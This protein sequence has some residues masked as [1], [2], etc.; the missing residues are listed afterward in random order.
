MMASKVRKRHVSGIGW[1][2]E[3]PGGRPVAIQADDGSLARVVSGVVGTKEAAAILGVLPPNFVRDWS[4]RPDFPRPIST[5]SSGRIWSRDEVADYAEQATEGPS[6]ERMLVI[7]RRAVWWQDSE[8]TLARPLI[9]VANVLARGTLDEVADVERFY[10]SSALRKAVL[11]AP[12]GILDRRAWNFW[13]LALGL[14]RS[15]PAPTRR[16][17]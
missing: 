2:V 8:R 6:R 9:F 3:S 14:D 16:V 10:G 7:A 5:L 15:T 17:A 11:G 13:L 12:A 4:T 1:I